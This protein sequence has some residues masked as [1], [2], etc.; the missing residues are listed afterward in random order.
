MYYCENCHQL[1]NENKCAV[2]G[3][4][5][6]RSPEA[7][8]YCAF[9]EQPSVLA[10]M[11]LDALSDNGIDCQRQPVMGAGIALKIGPVFERYRMFVPFEKL[12]QANEIAA[13]LLSDDAEITEKDTFEE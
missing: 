13:C 7:K 2:C 4:K 8:D 6:L 1:N 9:T 11:L 3:M 5:K 12:E 10:E